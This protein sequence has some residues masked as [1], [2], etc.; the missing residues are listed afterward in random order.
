MSRWGKIIR[1]V[2]LSVSLVGLLSAPGLAQQAPATEGEAEAKQPVKEIRL[3]AE[4]WKWI[5]NKIQ[6]KQGTLVKVEVRNSD[7]PHRFD[8]KDYDLKVSLPEGETVHFEFVADK[9]GTFRWKCGRPCG[10]GC[11][12]MRGELVVEE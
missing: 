8:L 10:N 6:V 9:V 3:Y 4:N 1:S 11:P 5:P 7:A 12:K 2:A